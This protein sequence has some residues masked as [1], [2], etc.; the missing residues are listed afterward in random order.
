MQCDRWRAGPLIRE[1]VRN[2]AD[3]RAKLFP[4]LVLAVLGGSS[5]AAFAGSE[6]ATLHTQLG[7]LQRDGRL[8]VEIS[9]T[10]HEEAA[11]IDR[12][13]CEALTGTAGVER[14]GLVVQQGFWDVAQLGANVSVS[15]VSRSLFPELDHAD[16]LVGS[17]LRKPSV[18]FLLTLPAGNVGTA[19]VMAL[20][21]KGVDT[22][23]ALLVALSPSDTTGPSCRVVLSPLSDGAEAIPRV[24]AALRNT[25]AAPISA[26]TQFQ[27]NINPVQQFLTR[28]SR[29]LALLLGALGGVAAAVINRVRLSE[30]AAYRLSGTSGRSLGVLIVLEQLIVG[31]AVAA[32]TS[33]AAIAV[34]VVAGYPA[35]VPA[36]VLSGVA[37][38]AVWVAVA[39]LLTIDIPLRRPTDLAKDR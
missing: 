34:V 21:P 3:V 20:Q 15:A 29:Y 33:V 18:D 2:V 13:S 24:V 9:S 32:A 6:A 1:A 10:K 11:A 36:I 19:H 25:G 22:N 23:S 8:V 39:A 4:V 17:A 5:L 27:E 12:T 16:A 14:A 35:S 7:A 37:A 28:A 26:N 30:F 31:G 38:G